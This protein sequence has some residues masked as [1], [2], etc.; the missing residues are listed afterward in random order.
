M[1]HHVVLSLGANLGDPLSA[2]TSALESL[3]QAEG[4]EVLATSSFYGTAPIGGPDQ[5][6]YI[7]AVAVVETTL[8]P[9]AILDL[10][11]QIEAD[12]DRV[13]QERWGPRTLDIDLVVYDDVVSADPTLTIPHPRAHQR[14][15]VLVPWH[16]LEPDAVLATFGPIADLIEHMKD[17]EI[18]VVAPP[19]HRGS[20]Q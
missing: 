12:H 4:V 10:A 1:T 15:F 17:Q 3:A 5:P 20:P 18:A 2:L 13:R 7:N 8:A 6:D 14:A 16:E 9:M 11:H 19:H